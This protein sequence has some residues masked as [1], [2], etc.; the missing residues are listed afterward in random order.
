MRQ[1]YPHNLFNNRRAA[2]P[3]PPL[4]TAY[5]CAVL[6]LLLLLPAATALSMAPD[7]LDLVLQFDSGSAALTDAAREELSAYM[8]GVALGRRGKVLVVGHADDKG[9]PELNLALSRKRADVV[10]KI[11]VEALGTPAE[12]VLIVGQGNAA[13][14][15]GNDTAKGRAR[16]R[17]VVVRLVGVAPPRIQR[18]YGSQDPRLV[19][20]D[21]LLKDA[22]AKLRLGRFDAA[23]ADLDRAAALGGDQYSRWHTAYGIAGFLGGQPSDKLRGYFEMALALDPHNSDARDFLGRVDA[24]LAFYQGRVLPWMGRTPGHPIQVTTRSQEHEYLQLFEAQA[25]AHHTLAQGTLDAWTCRTTEDRIV[26]YY[27]ET[28]AVLDWAYPGKKSQRGKAADRLY[29]LPNGEYRLESR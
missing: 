11:L 22:D 4:S 12:R 23:L 20:V 8:A 14:I 28:T 1:P 21:K 2:V 6:L 24:R 3:A 26:T 27:F 15:A 25:L 10:K 19:A 9:D 7:N 29:P 18:E 5:R 17:R 16:N 13:P